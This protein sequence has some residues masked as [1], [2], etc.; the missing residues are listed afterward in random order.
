MQSATR[1]GAKF[2]NTRERYEEDRVD[3][4]KQIGARHR[5]N[6]D[7]EKMRTFMQLQPVNAE[8][9]DDWGD[10]AEYPLR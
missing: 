7:I 2:S 9:E 5:P 3:R 4:R 8:F 1:K 10:D 6:R